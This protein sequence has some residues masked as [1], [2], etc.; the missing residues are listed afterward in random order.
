MNEIEY[1]L[2]K[3]AEKA[4]DSSMMNRIDVAKQNIVEKEELR[5][6][7]HEYEE[8][9]KQEAEYIRKI[10]E[11]QKK[12]LFSWVSY[13]D[14]G[15]AMDCGIVFANGRDEAYDILKKRLKGI[16]KL[17]VKPIDM[18]DDVVFIGHYYE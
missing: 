17:M 18:I 12:K 3:A 8:Y 4:N 13:P 2:R 6:K 7:R 15:Y 16:Y 14:T 9:L 11:N 10:E 1:A 5:S